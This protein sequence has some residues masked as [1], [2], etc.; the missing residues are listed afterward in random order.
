MMRH[1]V[2]LMVV[3]SGVL[4]FLWCYRSSEAQESAPGGP[5]KIGV[6]NVAEVLI[7]CQENVDW[8][9]QVQAQKGQVDR[10]LLRLTNEAEAIKQELEQSLVPGSPEYEKRLLEWFQKMAS[11]EATEEGHKRALETKSRVEMESLYEKLLAEVACL[12]QQ[13]GF[14]LVLAKNDR[15]VK[16][17]SMSDLANLIGSR[18][19]LFNAPGLEITDRVLENLNGAYRAEK[20]K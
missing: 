9:K 7:K 20:L 3:L 12:A 4:A 18:R 14:A 5:L 8:E 1:F 17:R 6:V 19:V 13:E 2:A 10:E 11:R 15:S 16:A